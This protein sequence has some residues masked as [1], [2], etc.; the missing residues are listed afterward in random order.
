MNLAAH[1]FMREGLHKI[2]SDEETIVAI[3][4]PLGHSAIGVIRISG[5]DALKIARQCFKSHSPDAPLQHRTVLVG[6][7]NDVHGSQIDQ[8]VLTFFH[9]PESYTGED[10]IEIS[11]HGSPFVLRRILKTA[12]LAGARLAQ[13]GEFTLRAVAHGKMDLVQAEAVREFIEAQTE[14]QAKT[15]LKQ[16]EGSVS[17]HVRPIKEKIIDVIARLEAGIDF[18]EDDV[19]VPEDGMIAEEI[20][21]PLVLLEALKDSF[22]YGK[23]L[24]EGLRIAILGK[25]N[26]GKSSLFN[27]LVCADRAIV[28]DIPGTT[29]DVITETISVDGVPLCFSDTAGI[30]RTGDRIE[31]IGI[32]RTFE[33][34]SEADLV[35]VVLDG[36]C[37]LDGDDFEV[38]ERARPRPHLIVVNKNDLSQEID[39]SRLNGAKR[40]LVSAKTGEG[41][42]GLNEALRSF[43]L[44]Q[45][46]SLNDDLILTNARQ[47]E[48]VTHAATALSMAESAVTKDVPHE[49][50]LLDLYGA[51]GALDEL[52]GD[53]VTD[54]IL[55]R[56]FS[57]FCVGK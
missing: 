26:V 12:N 50:V 19:D 17:K 36:S 1:E 33:T 29:R 11:A 48:A 44:C 24:A 38:I 3:S 2:V 42:E 41:I 31:A 53:V 47:W 23:I 54:D 57:S 4:T 55:Q 45:K 14:Q 39:L 15:A 30:R 34:L 35:I 56:I 28:T 51:L 49:M 18:A 46:T 43:L 20:R 5:P 13:P 22:G 37:G 10:V 16:M 8:V 40:V 7:W 9:G 6:I 52:T 27:R 25:P 32:N 21:Q